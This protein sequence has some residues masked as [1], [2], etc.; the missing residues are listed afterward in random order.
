MPFKI[1]FT[2]VDNRSQNA[3]KLKKPY[4]MEMRMGRSCSLMRLI[5]VK[6]DVSS[7]FSF[8]IVTNLCISVSFSIYILSFFIIVVNSVYP[9]QAIIS[10]QK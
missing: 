2:H 6:T 10:R 1:F 3:L 8:E 7:T 5:Q 4:G 9:Q